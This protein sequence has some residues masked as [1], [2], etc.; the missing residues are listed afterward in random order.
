MI[1]TALVM[2]IG[3]AGAAAQ[4]AVGLKGGF[5]VSRFSTT[6]DS[7]EV[8]EQ[9]WDLTG[10][11]FV[12]A[13]RQ[14][15]VTAQFE[16]LLSRRGAKIAGPLGSVGAIGTLRGTYLDLSAFVRAKA[17]GSA[18]RH[19]YIFAGATVGLE[20]GAEIVVDGVSE[21]LNDLTEDY[22]F[23][24]AFGIGFDVNHLV[25]EGRYTHGLTELIIAPELAGIQALH[26]W[27]SIM[28]GVRF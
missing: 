10:G 3:A 7:S 17:G 18:D 8:L 23:G 19:A 12:A 25:I 20:L 15:P 14:T 27:F 28:V 1:L 24:V 13:S 6:P 5:A 9:L 4:T 21:N 22:D 26:R 2:T 11:L 16:A